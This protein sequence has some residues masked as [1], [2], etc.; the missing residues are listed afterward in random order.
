MG[1]PRPS[2]PTDK[3]L[4]SLGWRNGRSPDDDDVVQIREQ[5]IAEAGIEGLDDNVVYPDE[6]GYAERA[7]EIFARDGVRA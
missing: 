1:H 2:M 3:P 7:A 4:G 5:L 6:L